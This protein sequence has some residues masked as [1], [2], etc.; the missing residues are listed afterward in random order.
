MEID[1]LIRVF[2]GN[3]YPHTYAKPERLRWVAA[4]KKDLL[5]IKQQVLV[6]TGGELPDN[7]KRL[8]LLGNE[9]PLTQV[10]E[11]A[12]GQPKA[13]SVDDDLNPNAN[14]GKQLS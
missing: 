13:D 10:E 4:K 9:E 7:L 12:G 2:G 3:R 11:T 1:R 5:Y 8:S 6:A 14:L